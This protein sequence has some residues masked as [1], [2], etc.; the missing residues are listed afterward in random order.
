MGK[1]VIEKKKTII[2]STSAVRQ[3]IRVVRQ[4]RLGQVFGQEIRRGSV[5][6]ARVRSRFT[7]KLY[8]PFPRTLT[9]WHWRRPLSVVLANELGLTVQHVVRFAADGYVF[10]GSVRVL[11]N[12]RE[13]VWR[14]SW[15]RTSDRYNTYYTNGLHSGPSGVH[16]NRGGG[17][18]Q[19]F[20]V[21]ERRR[22]IP[23]PLI[24]TYI[25]LHIDFIQSVLYTYYTYVYSTGTRVLNA[26]YLYLYNSTLVC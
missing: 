15:P 2:T 23:P 5:C 16:R 20:E 14:V 3:Y 19:F 9:N 10:T 22:Y 18:H 6:V 12:G 17:N 8:V 24:Y 26:V 7:K 21:T 11:R 4:V 13:T 25:Q 1:I